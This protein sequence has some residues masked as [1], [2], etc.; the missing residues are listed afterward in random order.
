M[1]QADLASDGVKRWGEASVHRGCSIT[2]THTRMCTHA[3]TQPHTQPH[4]QGLWH[5]NNDIPST[6]SLQGTKLECLW[7]LILSSLR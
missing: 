4:T 5:L 7:H 2:L 1:E 3:C 6:N